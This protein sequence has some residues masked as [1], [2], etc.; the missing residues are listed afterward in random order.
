MNHIDGTRLY[1]AGWGG[2]MLRSQGR[3]R[4]CALLGIDAKKRGRQQDRDTSKRRGKNGEDHL[5]TRKEGR[6]WER[7]KGQAVQVIQGSSLR[8]T[9]AKQILSARVEP[10]SSVEPAQLK[11]FM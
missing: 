9:N 3:G 10:E 2:E 7:R 1:N 11:F 6:W 8:C 5:R 4:I